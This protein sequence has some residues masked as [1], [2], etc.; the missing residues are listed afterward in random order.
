MTCISPPEPEVRLL[1]AF[2]DGEA[3]PETTLHLQQCDHCRDRAKTLEREQKLLTSRLYRASCPSTDELGEF[4]LRMLPSDRIL[5]ISQHVRECPLCTREIDQLKE[6]LSDLAPVAEGN[7]LQQTKQLVAQLVSGRGAPSAA[8]EPSFAL[9]GESDGPLT[10]EAGGILI[11]ID[12][13]EAVDGKINILGQ[14]AADLQDD[15]TAALVKLKQKDQPELTTTVDDLGAFRFEGLSPGPV[16]I[17]IEARD[18]TEIVIPAFE[19][20]D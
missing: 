20:T 18:G 2:L 4:H 7:L 5:V 8:G 10:Y 1:M 12:I 3:D 13:Q 6:F 19:S 11:V 15:W 9:R 16:D 14:V 17:Q